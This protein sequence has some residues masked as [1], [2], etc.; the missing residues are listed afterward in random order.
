MFSN[1]PEFIDPEEKNL[2]YYYNRNKQNKRLDK[3]NDCCKDNKFS[4]LKSTKGRIFTF[5]VFFIAIAV[6]FV[7][8]QKK[9]SN[10]NDDLSVIETDHYKITLN[11]YKIKENNQLY[12]QIFLLNKVNALKKFNLTDAVIILKAANNQIL[13]EK[14]LENAELE[15]G[16]KEVKTVLNSFDYNPQINRVRITFILNQIKIELE[17]TIY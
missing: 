1:K 5:G 16:F 3:N 14:K 17:K 4:I 7:Y 8:S 12:L 9:V 2:I 15:L 10:M 11:A 6:F 13:S